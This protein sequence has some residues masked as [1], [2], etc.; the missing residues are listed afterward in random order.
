LHVYEYTE[1]YGKVAGGSKKLIIALVE[2]LVVPSIASAGE[3]F[4]LLYGFSSRKILLRM[5]KNLLGGC[6][7]L[8]ALFVDELSLL[9]GWLEAVHGVFNSMLWNESVAGKDDYEYNYELENGGAKNV[10]HH[11]VRHNI[12]FS[13]LRF[14]L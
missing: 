5:I 14:S 8:M 9:H 7:V 4:S 10:L 6:W 13:A 2:G 12:V 3:D 1:E 11:L